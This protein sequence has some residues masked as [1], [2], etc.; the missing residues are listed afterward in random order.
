MISAS[1]WSSRNRICHRF[2]FLGDAGS[3]WTL[4]TCVFFNSCMV[5]FHAWR[6]S[7]ESSLAPRMIGGY[8]E[9]IELK[10]PLSTWLVLN[11]QLVASTTQPMGQWAPRIASTRFFTV[12]KDDILDFPQVDVDLTLF[13]KQNTL[14]LRQRKGTFTG[15][16]THHLRTIAIL[17]QKSI[18]ARWVK[19]STHQ[20]QNLR[21]ILEILSNAFY[22]TNNIVNARKLTCP[23]HVP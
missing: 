6:L 16:Q 23:L 15:W 20:G 7:I 9:S 11:L 8:F 14:C 19:C 13:K 18:F 1:W 22:T 21:V 17:C 4:S 3:P 12:T 10:W 2:G 5:C